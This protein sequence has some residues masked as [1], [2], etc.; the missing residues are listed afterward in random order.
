MRAVSS[1]CWRTRARASPG[2][3][4]ALLLRALE[5]WRGPPLAEFA[6]EE[7]AQTEARRLDELRLVAV[8]ERIAADI[9]LGR[10]ADVVPELE[11]SS[12]STRSAS[13]LCELHMLA[14][15]RAGRQADALEAYATVRAALDELG[16][17]P[18]EGLRQLQAE[19]L[20]GEA[21]GLSP[22]ERGRRRRDADARS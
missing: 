5:L 4:R 7:W 9:E 6:F 10:A 2:E 18:G 14:L 12:A 17:E 20:R 8:E 13:V 16:L 1:C 15:Y 19:I 11:R 22:G 21:T 3:R